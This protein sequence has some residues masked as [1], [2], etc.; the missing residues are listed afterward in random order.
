[1]RSP[2]GE[3]PAEGSRIVLLSASAERKRILAELG[4]DCVVPDNLIDAEKD[5]NPICCGKLDDASARVLDAKYEAYAAAG[6]F[7]VAGRYL[8]ADTMISCVSGNQE[9]I[10]GKCR[11]RFQ[12]DM[13]LD[14]YS[15]ADRVI[16]RSSAYLI[17]VDCDAQNCQAGLKRRFFTDDACIFLTDSNGGNMITERFRMEYLSRKVFLGRAG[18]IECDTFSDFGFR[19]VGNR[20]TIRGL[21][22]F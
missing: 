11:N 18:A 13:F 16:I 17:D 8:I 20:Q 12:A 5:E 7:D 19:I 2:V 15:K 21:C 10:L 4:Y 14:L 3:N 1:M 22:P 6:R 9:L